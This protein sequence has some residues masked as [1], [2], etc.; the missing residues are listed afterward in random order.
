MAQPDVPA[1]VNS[2]MRQGDS[3]QCFL[4][5][6]VTGHRDLREDE[7]PRI[8][9]QVRQLFE[10]LQQSFP[11]LPIRVLNP[12]AD[13]ADRLVARVAMDCGIP[14]IVPLPMPQESYE[15]D[16]ASAESVQEFRQLLAAAEVIPLPL[17][18]GV[19]AED[20]KSSE[21]ARSLQYAQMGVFISNHCQ[22]LLAIWDGT[23]DGSLGGTSQ[24]VHYHLNDEM[25]GY[26]DPGQSHNLLADNENDLVYIIPC[27]REGLS[28]SEDPSRV[29]PVWMTPASEQPELPKAHAAQMTHMQRMNRDAVQHGAGGSAGEDNSL[30]PGDTPA[31]LPDG[32]HRLDACFQTADRLANHFQRRVHSSLFW[33]HVIAVLM[34]TAFIIY[35]E[36]D[37][38]DLWLAAFLLTFGVGFVLF[39]L[40]R[41]RDWHRKYLDYRALAE[42]LRV[43]LYW[44]LAGV[45]ETADTEFTYDNFLQKQDLE[46]G[47]IRHVMR[48]VSIYRD[49]LEPPDPAWLPWV[50]DEWVGDE[51][52]QG[53]QLAYY[54][55][56]AAEKSRRY[57]NTARLGAIA[58]WA[59][60]LTAVF[61]LVAGGRLSEQMHQLVLVV[62]GVLPLIAGVR[63]T[64]SFKKADKE[65]IKQYQFMDRIFLNARK[66]LDQAN[67]LAGRRRI[68]EALGHAALEEHAEWIDMHR[69]R[70]LEHSGL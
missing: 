61:L 48:A 66:R 2:D 37:G 28:R 47:W 38:S 70:P 3:P 36:F 55:R 24:V 15:R 62:I 56:K 43:Q 13:G 5:I 33:I 54:A 26:I 23:P 67:T 40:A 14:L 34:G 69:D 53:G 59:G 35:S 1:Q 57:R 21:T 18:Q 4:T 19:T 9:D 60:M 10:N 25:P 51:N 17:G 68:L 45:V 39:L 20:L 11:D 41:R 29:S 30:L 52:H 58:L 7:L 16:L 22:I 32:V 64:Y 31:P 49:R 42:G 63:D 27:A 8:A 6:G 44:N 65:L 12:L 46:L 50:I